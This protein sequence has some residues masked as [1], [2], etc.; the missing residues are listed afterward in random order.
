MSSPN[1]I[2]V[3]DP[4][5]NLRDVPYEQLRAAVSAGGV[6]AHPVQDPSGQTRMVPVTRLSEAVQ[7]G[8]KIVNSP[9]P[10]AQLPAHYGFTPGN[11]ASNIW[12]GAKSVVQGTYALGKD[13]LTNPNWVEGDTST[14]HKFVEQPMLDQS[15]K[16]AQ[17]FAAGNRVEGIGHTIASGLPFVGPW[18]ASLGE[19]AGTGDIGG[20]LA[21]GAGQVGTLRAGQSALSRSISAA[22]NTSPVPTYPGAPMP[23]SPTPE[24]LQA[25]GLTQGATV[26]PPEPSDVLGQIPVRG[27]AAVT[28]SAASTLPNPSPEAAATIPRT[29]SG[30]SALGQVLSRLDNASLL[31]IA[32]SRG[33]DVRQEALLKAGTANGRLITKIAQDFSPD[34]LQEFGAR[35]L[36]NSRFQHQFSSQMTPEAWSTIATQTYFPQVRL[37]QTVLARTQKA[38]SAADIVKQ[39]TIRRR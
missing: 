6:P 3:F 32:R 2:P 30:E 33:I 9:V 19:Q 25:R 16:A 28:P 37:P 31:R 7:A 15:T 5:G 8:G 35:Y 14:L 29:L 27:Q 17:S 11:V 38:M 4:E 20:A 21:K 18:A 23:A 22:R 39:A 24:L 12:E 36:E 34:E 13:L 26:P 10:E 1:I